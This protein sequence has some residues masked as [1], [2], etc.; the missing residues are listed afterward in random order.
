MTT[1][2]TK[3]KREVQEDFVRFKTRSELLG[4][5]ALDKVGPNGRFRQQQA[6][7]SDIEQSGQRGRD[8]D[9]PPRPRSRSRRALAAWARATL[10]S[11]VALWCHIHVEALAVPPTVSA[12][13]HCSQVAKKIGRAHV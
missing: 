1:S 12:P 6:G 3:P 9:P 4:Q 11:I 8:N 5:Y 2:D 10:V 7:T 13:S